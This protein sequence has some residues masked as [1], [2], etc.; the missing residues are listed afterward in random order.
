MGTVSFFFSFLI[1][2]LIDVHSMQICKW[3]DLFIYNAR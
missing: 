2:T 3:Y 1:S